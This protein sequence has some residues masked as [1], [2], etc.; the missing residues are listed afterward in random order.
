MSKCRGKKYKSSANRK[1]T[2]FLLAHLPQEHQDP[3]THNSEPV[4][5][6][7][8]GTMPSRKLTT[9][10]VSIPQLHLDEILHPERVTD[11]AFGKGIT[12]AMVRTVQLAC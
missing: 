1:Y 6:K 5:A 8:A 7:P 2:K 4:S 9:V 3:P 10:A 12:V 11:A